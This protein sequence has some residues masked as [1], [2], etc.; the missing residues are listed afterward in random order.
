MRGVT[1]VGVGLATTQDER[2]VLWLASGVESTSATCLYRGTV[3]TGGVVCELCG[4][5][6]VRCLDCEVEGDW[7]GLVED[8]GELHPFGGAEA[9][10]LAC[11][12]SALFLNAVLI[13]DVGRMVAF[14]AGGLKLFDAPIGRTTCGVGK[15]RE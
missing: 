1:V 15:E 4:R 10:V 9:G 3:A 5:L 8:E 14:E 13:D 7:S 11:L 12:P 2:R 6:E